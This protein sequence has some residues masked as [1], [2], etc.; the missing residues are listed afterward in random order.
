MGS[1]EGEDITLE[2]MLEDENENENVEDKIEKKMMVHSFFQTLQ[3]KEM[4]VWDMH[5]AGSR[6]EK[7]SQH[8]GTSQVQVS[9]ILKRINERA[10]AFGRAQGVAK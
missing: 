4:I 3:D 1:G 8:I 2:K 5:S 9:R 6:Q 10:V 7:I